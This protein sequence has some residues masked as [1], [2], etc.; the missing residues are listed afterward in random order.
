PRRPTSPRAEPA[1]PRASPAPSRAPASRPRRVRAAA[2]SCVRSPA[3]RG[4]PRRAGP[5]CR[6][7][8]SGSRSSRRSLVGD[9]R[10]QRKLARPLHGDGDLALV[11]PA[12][13][14][15]AAV[16]DLALLRHVAPKLVD[17]LVV[18]LVDLRLAEE[19]RLAPAGARR[20]A[21][22]ARRGAIGLGCCQSCSP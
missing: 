4:P 21:L 2:G 11:A 1:G 9:V 14:A 13:P 19:A 7:P 18:D 16:A 3:R 17:V 6:R 20:A 10:E 22:P 8:L 5:A 15:D 12:R